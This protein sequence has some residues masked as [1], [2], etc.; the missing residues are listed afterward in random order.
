MPAQLEKSR[1][2]RTDQ[3]CDSR[4]VGLVG[5]VLRLHKDLPKAREMRDTE[6]V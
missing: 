2:P 5:Q 4:M 6:L 3:S 1:M